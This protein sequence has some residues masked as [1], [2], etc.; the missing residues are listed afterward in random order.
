MVRNG[1]GHLK[2][3]GVLYTSAH[4]VHLSPMFD[5]VTTAIYQYERYPGGPSMEDNTMALKL[6]RGKR[7]KTK[8]YPLTDEMVQFGTQAWGAQALLSAGSSPSGQS[9]I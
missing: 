1:D 4:D 5:V 7:S 6:F 2:N 9:R 3:F 8:T